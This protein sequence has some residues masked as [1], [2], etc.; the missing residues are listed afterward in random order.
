MYDQHDLQQL[1]EAQRRM[2][3]YQNASPR[4]TNLAGTVIAVAIIAAAVLGAIWVAL[5]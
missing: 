3:A 4:G 5:S 2:G 1:D